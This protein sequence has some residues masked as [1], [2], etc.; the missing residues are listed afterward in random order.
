MLIFCSGMV[1]SG[2]TWSFNVCRTILQ[3]ANRPYLSG[4]FGEGKDVDRV[5]QEFDS[6]DTKDLLIK[7]HVPGQSSL[8]LIQNG[9][10]KN[11]FTYRD[12]RD[13]ICSRIKFENSEFKSILETVNQNLTL[14]EWYRKSSDTC[15]VKFESMMLDTIEEI[16]KI[17]NYLDVFLDAQSYQEIADKTSLETAQK[18][19]GDLDFLLS[20]ASRTIDRETLL[21]T[22]HL[23][24][25]RMG[26]WRDEL[27]V[28]QQ[29]E[30]NNLFRDWLIDLEYETEES[31]EQLILS[32]MAQIDWQHQ[33]Q[34]YW[35]RG[36]YKLASILYERAIEL[37][38]NVLSHYW[39]L[40][41]MLL[42]QGEENE[43][44]AIWLSVMLEAEPEDVE[45]WTTE[46]VQVLKTE[47]TRQESLEDHRAA[48]IIRQH[49][50][51][52][53]PDNLENLLQ[54]IQQSLALEITE[55]LEVVLSD[56]IELLKIE[57]V[58]NIDLCSNTL[59]E[60]LNFAPAL[61]FVAEFTKVCAEEFK[62][63]HSLESFVIN[64]TA[65]FLRN[66]TLS[67]NVCAQFVEIC[68]QIQPNNLPILVNLIN[69][70]QD[71]QKYDKSLELT[72][73][74]LSVAN[75][76]L[77]RIAGHYLKIR[78]LLN[79]GGNFTEASVTHEAYEN[80]LTELIGLAKAPE[81]NLDADHLFNLISTISFLGY[82]EDS[83]QRANG[84]RQK[85]SQFWQSAIKKHFHSIQF[86]FSN[87]ARHS[88]KQV[89]RIGYL[90]G[91]LSRHSV[92][93]IGRWI[94]Q[95]FD[96]D[97]F[98]T[99]AYSLNQT[100][101]S[102][103]H[104]IANTTSVF[105]D[106]SQSQTIPEI[107]ELIYQ[108]EID[109]LVDLD[110]LTSNISCAVMAL[111]PAPIQVTWLGFDAAEIPSIDYFIADSYVL[112]NSA[113]DY[114][115][116]TIWRLP[117]TYIAV[118]G[119]EVGVPTLRRE[120]LDIPTDA[121]VYFSSQ[122]GAKRHPDNVRLQMRILKEVPN[123]YFLIKGLHTD[124]ELVKS[125]F[126]EIA[127]EEGVE[128]TRLRFLPNV[129]SEAVHRANLGIADVVLDTY[130]YNGTTTTLETLWMGVPVVTRVGEQFAS[131]Q[132]YA[133]LMNVGVTEGI[134]WT[135][136]QYV[137]WGVRLGK[138]AALRQE[139]SWKLR[140]S[141]H[142]S[143]LWK[144]EKFTRDL[145]DAYRQM[146]EMYLKSQR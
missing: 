90:S 100:D 76:L 66:P 127:A 16:K 59:Q 46:L 5:V 2:S 48:W 32:F 130:P 37:E 42:L 22:G 78:G 81:F 8:N 51:E 38:S 83:P 1:R 7:A 96:R 33:A 56:A 72:D 133:L 126:E 34:V 30:I 128:L 63:D 146:W 115:S 12:P 41:L 99:Y 84:F 120:Q 116:E 132:G 114:Y 13:I 87:R 125:F 40:G 6:Q 134:A 79:S 21:Q 106:I 80:L 39:H 75:T 35:Y 105:R 36:D 73:R 107:A 95:N 44:Q 91:C 19:V 69:L 137:E 129:P 135:D 15:F 62:G 117:E 102:I 88:K 82:L 141:R 85:F 68:H 124:T 29:L 144:A 64:K 60:L 53:A 145:E 110:S 139:V 43:A 25:A 4:Y 108:D 97:R 119:F 20:T 52:I 28:E 118:D 136:E 121:V 94:F 77:D 47:A 86:D 140:M 113:Q 18:I 3:A 65:E 112:P 103:Q 45:E 31:W 92:G 71:T 122:T 93:S 10:A 54:L 131:R 27:N 109:I 57:D 58:P 70:Y 98:L 23:N 67:K 111:K 74:L 14:Y 138:D 11:I 9:I 104:F 101:D 17:A 142:S 61:P 49:I 123:S 50:R 24:G 26:R 143:P 55:D 89:L